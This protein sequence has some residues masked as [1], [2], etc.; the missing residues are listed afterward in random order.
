MILRLSPETRFG[1]REED[2]DCNEADGDGH[3]WSAASDY[4][5]G[6]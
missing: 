2:I 1:R 3:R 5:R 6:G 4:E